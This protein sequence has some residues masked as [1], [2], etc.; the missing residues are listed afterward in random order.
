MWKNARNRAKEAKKESLLL[1]LEA[2]RIKEH[3][4]LDILDSE[5][6]SD[7]EEEPSGFSIILKNFL[8]TQFI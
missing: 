7:I 3:Y 1:Y 6:E 4:M 5:S 8:S 2:K